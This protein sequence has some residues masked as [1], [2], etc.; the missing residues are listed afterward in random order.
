MIMLFVILIANFRVS[1]HLHEMAVITLYRSVF[2]QA[3]LLLQK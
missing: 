2:I 3:S 1:R